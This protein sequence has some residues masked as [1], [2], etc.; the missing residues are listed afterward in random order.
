[1][2]EL[3]GSRAQLARNSFSACRSPFLSPIHKLNIL[4]EIQADFSWIIALVRFLK[5][6]F[7]EISLANAGLS[8]GIAF[9]IGRTLYTAKRERETQL[10]IGDV[11]A[12]CNAV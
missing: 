4:F 3:Q 9:V 11:L 10:Q 7:L 6:L 12:S 1:M 2:L 5:N 8:S